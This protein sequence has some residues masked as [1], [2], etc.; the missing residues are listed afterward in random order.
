MNSHPSQRIAAPAADRRRAPLVWLAAALALL[1]TAACGSERRTRPEASATPGGSDASALDEDAPPLDEPVGAASPPPGR[2]AASFAL[3]VDQSA[4]MAGFAEAGQLEPIVTAFGGVLRARGASAEQVQVRSI[5]AQVTSADEKQL[6]DRARFRASRADLRAA[7]AS[8]ELTG[9]D[10]ALIIT[11]GQP[12]RARVGR[13]ACSPLGTQDVSELA[14]L[15][16]DLLASGRG[17][18]LVFERRPFRGTAFLN[19]SEPTPS[20]KAA[21]RQKGIRLS[22][23]GECSHPY[24]GERVVLTIAIAGAEVVEDAARYIEGYLDMRGDAEALRLHPSPADRWRAA[25]PEVLVDDG[26]GTSAIP[27]DGRAG[28]W[29]SELRCPGR[30]VAVRLCLRAAP[31]PSRRAA[32]MAA[33]AAPRLQLRQD[34]AG[35]PGELYRLPDR[36]G[37]DATT[38][39]RLNAGKFDC[40][41]V[42]ARY[43]ELIQDAPATPSGCEARADEQAVEVVVACGCLRGGVRDE[44]LQWSQAHQPWARAVSAFAERYGARAATW[45]EE[46][47]RVNGLSALLEAL[48]QRRDE[49]A[50]AIGGLQ[51]RLYPPK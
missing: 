23:R 51:L 8:P 38:L 41:A 39:P 46:P 43:Q 1:I 22:C 11:D 34:P 49:G 33:L 9:P 7:L 15:L 10:L 29:T 3:A 21:L 14:G 45:Y 13:A 18:W 16:G 6:W 42:W 31:P 32:A 35:E 40:T 17:V 12:T 26:R 44:V 19:C 5:G 28:S 47:E 25:R 4:S 2:K 37:F 36:L 20:I 27:V 24:D 48:A 50:V 30:D